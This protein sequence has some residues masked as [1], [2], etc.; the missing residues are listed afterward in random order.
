MNE[1]TI[2]EQLETATAQAVS[3]AELVTGLQANLDEAVTENATLTASVETLTAQSE[4]LTAENAEFTATI[5]TLTVSQTELQ[6]TVATQATALSH[7]AYLDA[8]NGSDGAEESGGEGSALTMREQYKSISSP[9][10][11]SKFFRE[12]KTAILA[13]E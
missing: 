10:E 12:N 9:T 3:S 5:S 4:L 8:V 7:P 6:A 1:P 2:I 11:K 13:G